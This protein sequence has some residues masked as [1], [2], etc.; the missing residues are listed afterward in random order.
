MPQCAYFPGAHL[1]T[2]GPNCVCFCSYRFAACNQINSLFRLDRSQANRMIVYS[3]NRACSM[4]FWRNRGS[5]S[6]CQLCLLSTFAKIVSFALVLYTLT[7]STPLKTAAGRSLEHA[8][9]SHSTFF[10]PDVYKSSAKFIFR[11]LENKQKQLK[12]FL[13]FKRFFNGRKTS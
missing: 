6:V 9:C 1:L 11:F 13:R 8:R 10:K 5:V 12:L 3:L 4:G 7:L 2:S